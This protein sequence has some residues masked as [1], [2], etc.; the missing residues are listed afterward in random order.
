MFL[1]QRN[2]KLTVTG[3][4]TGLVITHCIGVTLYLILGTISTST[5][6]QNSLT[7]TTTST[8]THILTKRKG[9]EAGE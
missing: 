9:R 8:H 4:L 3:T 2:A 5:Y 6:K 7:I 1:T